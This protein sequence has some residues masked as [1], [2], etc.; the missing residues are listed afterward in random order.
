M[1]EIE[2]EWKELK[3]REG[4]KRERGGKGKGG[5]K[6]EKGGEGGEEKGR[7]GCYGKVARGRLIT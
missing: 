1:R 2:G 3:E 6:R 7:E 4:K 5:K